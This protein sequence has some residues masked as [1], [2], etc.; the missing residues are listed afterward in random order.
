MMA[1]GSPA[2][3]FHDPPPPGFWRSVVHVG[4]G[5]ELD[6]GGLPDALVVVEQGELE[7]EC[8]SGSRRRFGRGSMIPIARFP[9][10]RM[11]SVGPDSLVLVAVSRAT[12]GGTDD[13]PSDP[14]SYCDD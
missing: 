13:F 2:A 11:Q 14:G 6:P 12:P 7:L 8:R 9:I 3:L 4:T 10:A 5:V 1:D